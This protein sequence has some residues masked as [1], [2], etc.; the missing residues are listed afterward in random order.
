TTFYTV[1]TNPAPADDSTPPAGDGPT[2]SIARVGANL[3]LEYTGT[4]EST[5]ALAPAD[6]QVVAG[7]TSPH[8]VPP[9]QPQRY[10]RSRQ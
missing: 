5:G 7:A 6:W 10:Y 4:L 8:M 1:L 2:L 3:R 9:N